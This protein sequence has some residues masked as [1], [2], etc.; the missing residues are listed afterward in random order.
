MFIE[1]KDESLEGFSL[2]MICNFVG[3]DVFI[4][5]NNKNNFQNTLNFYKRVS[6]ISIKVNY[7]NWENTTLFFEHKETDG[8]YFLLEKINLKRFLKR[9]HSL[10]FNPIP[11]EVKNSA[12]EKKSEILKKI[13]NFNNEDFKEEI[14]YKSLIQAFLK[15]NLRIKNNEIVR[16]ETADLF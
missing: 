4:R 14:D 12:P 15:E 8:F 16:F 13:A 11:V 3:I 2:F 5:K 10:V 6:R 1:K 9:G 7:T